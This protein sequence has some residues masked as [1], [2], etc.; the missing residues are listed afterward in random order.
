MNL[1]ALSGSQ[2]KAPGFAGGYL[3]AGHKSG[4]GDAYMKN[5]IILDVN[6]NALKEYNTS[7]ITPLSSPP[8]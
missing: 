8:T 4:S 5:N 2:T 3:L 1:A 6:G 7:N